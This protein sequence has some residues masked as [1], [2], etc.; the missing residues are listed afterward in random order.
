M[1][2]AM[3]WITEEE[4]GQGM[5]EYIIIVGS[6]ALAAIVGFRTLGTSISAKASNIA[7]QVKNF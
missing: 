4:S 1:K 6:I 7:T 3:K 5:V 2:E